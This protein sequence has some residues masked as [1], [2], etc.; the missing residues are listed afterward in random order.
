MTHPPGSS[1][2]VDASFCLISPGLALSTSVQDASSRTTVETL[3]IPNT[4][5]ALER[6]FAYFTSRGFSIRE[7]TCVSRKGSS[8]LSFSDS[9]DFL[10]W[11]SQE[12]LPGN[13]T[14]PGFSRTT[15]GSTCSP[16]GTTRAASSVHASRKK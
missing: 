12:L 16:M 6:T 11:A 5:D 1:R 10:R 2:S 4:W 8:T 14:T 15:P 13:P 3:A 7:I 9:A